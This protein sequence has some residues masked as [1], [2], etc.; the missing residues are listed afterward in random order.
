MKFI[1]KFFYW[2]AGLFIGMAIARVLCSLIDLDS[3][4]ELNI[5]TAI[6]LVS[7]IYFAWKYPKP[8]NDSNQK[9]KVLKAD[10]SVDLTPFKEAC[11]QVPTSTDISL[12]S[13]QLLP[14]YDEKH[15]RIGLEQYIHNAFEKVIESVQNSSEDPIKAAYPGLNNIR[16]FCNNLGVSVSQFQS[17]NDKLRRE[18]AKEYVNRGISTT[19]EF[20]A[21]FGDL[22][23][24]L[25][26][27]ESLY[28]AAGN[29]K[30][31]ETHTE[32]KYQAGSRGVSIRLAKGLSY[33]VG[34]SRG[35]RISEDRQRCIG[36]GAV[37]VS[38]K[39][40]YY[41]VGDQSVRVPLQKIVS[42][43]LTGSEIE[44]VKEAAHPRPVTFIF[45]DA[46]DADVFAYAMKNVG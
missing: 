13:N 8:A 42:V 6:A 41:Y 10:P 39:H 12:L 46:K 26:R 25:Q 9:K 28:Y 7:S 17:E 27:N 36:R 21:L 34:N 33:R 23:F 37:A 1:K 18:L 24:V 19:P 14:K 11:E 16:L 3:E 43:T 30:V 5:C 40:V 45:N 15:I 31:Y 35:K 32:T 22:P 29:V 20:S 4:T 44:F 38:S 2:F